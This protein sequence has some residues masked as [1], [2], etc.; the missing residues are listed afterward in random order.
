MQSKKIDRSYPTITTYIPIS[1]LPYS[2]LP[3]PTVFVFKPVPGS[4]RYTLKS[5]PV[6]SLVSFRSDPIRSD[7][8]RTVPVI[9]DTVY[10][11]NP[12]QRNQLDFA[13]STFIGEI[14]L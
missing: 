7:P 4:F 14:N 13:K 5:V 8:R 6:Y 1:T 12:N 3:Y 10:G 9:L 2:I 11:G